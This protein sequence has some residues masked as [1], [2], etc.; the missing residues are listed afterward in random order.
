[1]RAATWLGIERSSSPRSCP[2]VIS[3]PSMRRKSA[4]CG[5]SYSFMNLL[6]WRSSIVSTSAAAG[7]SWT[8]RRYARMNARSCSAGG[9]PAIASRSTALT[10]FIRASNSEISRSSLLLK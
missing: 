5:F 7:S 4:N 8:S 1:M 3:P 9:A 6:D 2:A 10:C